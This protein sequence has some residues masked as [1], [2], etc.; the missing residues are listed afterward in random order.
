MGIVALAFVAATTAMPKKAP[1]P[2]EFK[3]PYVAPLT[4]D[5]IQV[6]LAGSKSFLIVDR[7]GRIRFDLRGLQLAAPPGF[8]EL[9]HSQKAFRRAPLWAAEIRKALDETL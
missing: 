9:N 2:I 8:S 5:K 3:G 7:K 1:E 6:N 4:E